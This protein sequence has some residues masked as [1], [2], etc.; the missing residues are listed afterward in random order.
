MSLTERNLAFLMAHLQEFADRQK[1]GETS[2]FDLPNV[3]YLSSSTATPKEASSPPSFLEMEKPGK[4]DIRSNHA[5]WPRPTRVQ[6]PMTLAQMREVRSSGSKK[7]MKQD[8]VHV[9]GNG[10]SPT[11]TVERAHFRFTERSLKAADSAMASPSREKEQANIKAWVCNVPMQAVISSMEQSPKMKPTSQIPVRVKRPTA[12]LRPKSSTSTR[13]TISESV[14]DSSG[15]DAGYF[16]DDE[17]AGERIRR[18]GRLQDLQ[19]Q[20]GLV[21]KL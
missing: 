16:M 4:E 17:R 1:R 15:D 3:T 21:G 2:R 12:V 19:G 7:S 18:S 5:Q 14:L 9:P 6:R 20:V 13:P 10:W 11:G 8:P